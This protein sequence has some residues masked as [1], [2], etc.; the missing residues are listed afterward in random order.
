MFCQITAKVNVFK[1]GEK[2]ME[3]F[4]ISNKLLAVLKEKFDID[5]IGKWEDIKD[6]NLLGHKLCFE[7][8]EMVYL[9]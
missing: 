7:P 4:D 8:R 6:I 3:G 9:L 5:Y 1:E 2:E